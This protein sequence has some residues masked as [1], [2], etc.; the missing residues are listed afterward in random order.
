MSSSS[1]SC[2]CSSCVPDSLCVLQLLAPA[3][4][5][6][7]FLL[8][9]LSPLELN[10]TEP[11]VLYAREYLQQVSELIN[12]TERRSDSQILSHLLHQT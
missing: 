9:S 5:W 12:K 1:S 8:S 3:V 6:L 7:D 10:D 11:V 2:R 4:D